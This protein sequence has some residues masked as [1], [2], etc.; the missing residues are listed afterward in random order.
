MRKRFVMGLLVG[1]V[2]LAA[3]T[4]M[5]GDTKVLPGFVCVH[6]SGATTTYNSS[7]GRI[8]NPSTTDVATVYCPIH[9]DNPGPRSTF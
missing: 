2:S 5:A 9:R 4:A 3:A 6:V 8:L 1:A 7:Y